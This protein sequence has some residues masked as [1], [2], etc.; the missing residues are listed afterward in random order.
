MD[1]GDHVTPLSGMSM[2][3]ART[4]GPAAYGAY[5]HTLWSYFVA[6]T[7]GMLT[8]AELF[9]RARHGV[10]PYCAKM[11]HDHKKRCIFQHMI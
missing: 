11:Y 10:G 6:P 3:P 9:L 4:F 7:L 2:N 8:A 1:K 5:W